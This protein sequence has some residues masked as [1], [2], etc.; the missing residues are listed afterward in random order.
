LDRL[1]GQP[2]QGGPDGVGTGD[3]TVEREPAAEVFARGSESH[4]SFDVREPDPEQGQPLVD[5]P[6]GHQSQA[7]ELRFLGSPL[8]LGAL[9]QRHI[10]PCEGA[11]GEV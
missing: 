3:G 1:V 11:N 4:I 5:V 10:V 8:I 9:A 6:R 7:G 2:R